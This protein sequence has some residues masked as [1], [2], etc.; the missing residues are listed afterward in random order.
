[1]PRRSK[2]TKIE[3]LRNV[4][5][6]AGCSAKELAHVAALVDEVDVPNGAALVKEGQPGGECFVVAEGKAKATVKGR[7]I[8]E[9]GPGAFF[10]ELALLDHGPRS[11]TVTAETAMHLLVLDPHSFAELI[12]D[13]P[14]V[15]RKLLRTLAERLRA[16]EK[17]VTH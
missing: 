14:S 10:G 1:M 4:S 13:V 17:R 9:Y 7:K 5:L 11:A 8:A 16:T 12:S 2:S 15:A 6:F 3:L